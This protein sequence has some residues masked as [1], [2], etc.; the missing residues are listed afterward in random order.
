MSYLSF[1]SWSAAQALPVVEY[2]MS[3]KN[4][5]RLP[6]LPLARGRSRELWTA[7]ACDSAQVFVPSESSHAQ[8]SLRYAVLGPFCL[9][10]AQALPGTRVLDLLVESA[11]VRQVLALAVLAACSGDHG[12]GWFGWFGWAGVG[13]ESSA[14]C[15]VLQVQAPHREGLGEAVGAGGGRPQQHL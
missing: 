7:G 14:T 9:S 6:R 3:F 13:A 12:F 15:E 8:A 2:Q 10:A 5:L 1:L 11:S 4:F